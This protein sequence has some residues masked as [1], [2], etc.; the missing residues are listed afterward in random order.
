MEVNQ[1]ALTFEELATA[2][3]AIRVLRW[4]TAVG[5]W[6]ALPIL[7]VMA[8]PVVAWVLL[9]IGVASPLLA[10]GLLAWTYHR[11]AAA[12]RAAGA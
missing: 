4:L 8:T 2:R 7:L 9:V 11:D 1:T 3:T 5:V 12:S 6:A 10:A